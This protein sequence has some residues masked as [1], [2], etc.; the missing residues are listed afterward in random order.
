MPEEEITNDKGKIALLKIAIV[1]IVILI[2]S[3]VAVVI[4]DITSKDEEGK[5]LST[6]TRRS[7]SISKSSEVIDDEEE[8]TT[9]TTDEITSE[10]STNINSTSTVTTKKSN[11]NTNTRTETYYVT[12]KYTY[13]VTQEPVTVI[14]SSP[15]TVVNGPS[16]YP[17]SVYSMENEILNLI[18]ADRRK[19]GY[20]E[21]RVAKELRALAE[22]AADLMYGYS[23]DE[24]KKYLYPNTNRR[25]FDNSNPSSEFLYNKFK[26]D[27]ENNKDMKY[28][29]IGV[30][31]KSSGT[32]YVL[33]YE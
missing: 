26:S 32:Y 28:V 27:I 23:S 33:I 18:N 1:I 10:V 22:E 31:K 29:G 4:L 16:G 15:R 13:V 9:T 8:T 7:I 17:D 11:S 19:R 21:V 30:I 25:Y 20:Q 3:L 5:K 2:L 6:T 24:V 14:P 12:T